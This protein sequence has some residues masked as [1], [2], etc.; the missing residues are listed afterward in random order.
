MKK[1]IFRKIIS[2][3]V[4]FF[5][6]SSFALTL[7]VWVI[8]AVN[9][10]DFV[11]EDGHSFSVYFMFSILTI[12]KI[13]SKISLFIFFVSLFAVLSKYE[14]N[15]EILVLWTNGLKK[16]KFINSILI[17]SIFVFLF[18]II[19]TTFIVPKTQDLA[20]SYI[21][22]SNI[23]YFPSLIKPKKFIDTVEKLTLFVDEKNK[24]RMENI[25]LKDNSAGGSSQIVTAKSGYL[26]STEDKNYFVLEDGEL[27]NI[28]NKGTNIINFDKTVYNLSKYN[29]KTTT[30][31]KIQEKNTKL[32]MDCVNSL[33]NKN[34]EF[35]TI[36]FDCNKNSLNPILQE[37]YKRIFTPFYVLIVGLV[38]SCLILFSKSDPNY[39]K[40]KLLLFFVGVLFIVLSEISIRYVNNDFINNIYFFF[41]PLV[42][43]FSTYLYLLIKSKNRK[44]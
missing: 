23:E 35:K 16:I 9:Y 17:F 8:Q 1:L 36:T 20:R 10:L 30:Y 5:L 28:D 42:I 37:T 18:Q 24:F 12:P 25:F 33:I 15:N 7:I 3:V 29:T 32:L 4:S 13:F 6:V 14:E 11:S 39:I 21:R 43:A 27:V 19:L 44:I 26:V 41:L 34:I 40:K 22:S 38:A 2:D 31:P